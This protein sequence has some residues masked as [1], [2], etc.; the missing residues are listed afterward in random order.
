[1]RTAG[2]RQHH[3]VGIVWVTG[4]SGAGKSSVCEALK[5]EGHQAI[6][7]DW[8]GFSRWVHRSTGELVLDA[9]FPVPAGWLHDHAWRIDVRRVEEL[10]TASAGGATFLCG[11]AEIEVDV[12]RHFRS[13][14]CLVIDDETLRH[15][16]AT[17]TTNEFGKHPEELAAALTWNRS[18]SRRY[19][20][21]GASLV[22]AA[23]P[24]DE[25]VDEVLAVTAG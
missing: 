15:R 19:R 7:A 1:M 4:I 10:A 16:L 22:D 6:D 2:L 13:V 25:V 24:L 18:E 11:G 9:P 14:V 3:C 12:W 5:G 23:R 17:R 21:L 20:E 8:D